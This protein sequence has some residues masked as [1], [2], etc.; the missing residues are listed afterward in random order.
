VTALQLLAAMC[1]TGQPLSE[2]AKLMA[3]FPQ[4]VV[5]VDVA[6]KPPLEELAE[7]QAAIGAAEAELGERGRVLVRYSGTQSMCRIMVEGPSEEQTR[8][9]ARAIADAVEASIGAAA[10]NPAP[11]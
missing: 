7:V 3:L 9:L 8:R 1:D 5:N 10:P 6:R 11:S 2:L 4:E